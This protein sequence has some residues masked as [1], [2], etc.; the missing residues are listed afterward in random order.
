MLLLQDVAFAQVGDGGGDPAAGVAAADEGDAADLGGADQGLG[1]FAAAAAD[2]GDGDALAVDQGAREGEAG[3]AAVGGGLGDD[4]VAGQGLD[5]HGVDEDGHRVV[6]AGDVADRAGERGAVA[7]HGVDLVHVPA[8]AVDGPVDVGLGEAPG[9]ADLPDQEEGEQLAVLGEG[10]QGGGDARL[11]LGERDGAPGTV[12]IEGGAYGGMGA[13][14]VEAG[15]ACDGGAVDGRGG[16]EDTAVGVPGALPEVEDP[17]GP[18]GLGGGGQAALP[19]VG[20]GGAGLEDQGRVGHAGRV[21]R[22]GHVGVSARRQGRIS[23]RAPH[24]CTSSI[25]PVPPRIWL[26]RRGS[27]PVM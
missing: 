14:G 24:R 13:G 16:G 17:V 6:P 27:A 19:G 7:D 2:Q 4:G 1:E 15:Q 26:K 8:H 5:E 23:R 9:L 10:V 22:V 20:P 3:E 18:E 21:G 11:A 25:S 12:L